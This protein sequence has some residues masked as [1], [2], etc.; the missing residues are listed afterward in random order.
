MRKSWIF[1]FAV[2]SVVV[3]AGCKAK[4]STYKAAYEKAQEKQLADESVNAPK[5]QQQKV[6]ESVEEKPTTSK[7]S[8]GKVTTE[9]VTTV[10]SAD[11]SKLKTFNV[12]L[13]SF[14]ISTNASGLKDNLVADG[15]NAFVVQNANGWYRVIVASFDDRESAVN[16]RENIKQKYTDRFSDAWLLINQ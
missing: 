5:Q 15:Y 11:A 8:Q 14:S 3:L 10:N 7:P 12:V 9:R 1:T 13:G 4:E 16:F 6:E 2:A